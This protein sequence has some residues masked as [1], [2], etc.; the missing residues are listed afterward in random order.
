MSKEKDGEQTF[1]TLLL[2]PAS[3][4]HNPTYQNNNKKTKDTPTPATNTHAHIHTPHHPTYKHTNNIT[5][6]KIKNNY[7]KTLIIVI[8]TNF[9]GVKTDFFSNQK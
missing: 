5:K 2:P 1:R 3:Q 8:K 9:C 7:L 6:L 4:A